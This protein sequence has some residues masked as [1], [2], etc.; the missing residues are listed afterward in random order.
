M[1]IPDDI[2]RRYEAIERNDPDEA[3]AIITALITRCGYCP[4]SVAHYLFML[5]DDDTDLRNRVVGL[6]I[7]PEPH[8]DEVL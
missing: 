7:R 3:E 1:Q 5:Q 8:A 6:D 4:S 2:D